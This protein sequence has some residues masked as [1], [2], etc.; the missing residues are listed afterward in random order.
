MKLFVDTS[1]LVALADRNDQRHD[2][3]KRF[4]ETLPS[5]ARFYTS[6]YVIDETITRLRTL[7]GV[8]VA[9]KTAE[10]IWSSELYQIH[11]IDHTVEREA[12][13]ILRKYAD[14]RLSFT[15]CTTTVLLEQLDIDRIFAFDDDFRKLG[16]HLVPEVRR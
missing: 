11:A 7:A 9:A 8:E 5:A 12:L 14:H 3:A 1:A 16:Y 10:A 6:N 4:L 15:D 13:Q 2:A